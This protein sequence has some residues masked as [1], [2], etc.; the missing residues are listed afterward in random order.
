MTRILKALGLAM[1]AMASLVAVMAPA[2]HAETGALTAGMYPAFITGEPGAGPL[3]DIGGV[4]NVECA[5]ADWNSTIGGPAD[6]V[7]FKPVYANCISNP[8]GLPT[9]IT[10]NGCH[11]QIGVSRPGTTGVEMPTTGRLHAGLVC[12]AGTQLEIHVYENAFAHAGNVSTCTYDIFPQGPVLAGIY[13]NVV[14][15]PNDVLATINATFNGV[16][17]V[18]PAAICGAGMFEVLPITLTGKYTWRGYQDI[19]GMEGAPIPIEID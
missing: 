5:T 12:P 6:P 19:A 4:R 2:A 18:G 9:T 8:G 15:M 3:F 7:T 1:A 16:S 11:Y 10:V 13:H 17:T 14:G